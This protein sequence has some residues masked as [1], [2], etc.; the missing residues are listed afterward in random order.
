MIYY[1]ENQDILEAATDAVVSS[2]TTAGSMEKGL[3]GQVARVYPEVETEY[4]E[5]LAQG[6]LGIGKVWA[7]QPQG[8]GYIVVLFP[9]STEASRRSDP[10]YIK[11]GL[12]ALKEVVVGHEWKSLAV[13]KLGTGVGGLEWADVKKEIVDTFQDVLDKIDLYIYV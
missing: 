9:T 5:A 11:A 4:K 3:A 10:E 6:F 8:A 12:R 7:V 13:P 1:V 2:C